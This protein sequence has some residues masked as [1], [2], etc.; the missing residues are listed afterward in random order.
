M[1]ISKRKSGMISHGNL[2]DDGIYKYNPK[3]FLDYCIDYRQQA[4]GH[5]LSDSDLEEEVTTMILA[6]S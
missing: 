6:V 5:T 1:N 4:N 3:A 2:Y